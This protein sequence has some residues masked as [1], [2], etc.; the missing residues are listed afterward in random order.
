MVDTPYR[1][2]RGWA[3]RPR[4]AA[5]AIVA[6]AYVAAI[7]TAL[8]VVVLLKDSH[9][10][11][12]FFW[13]DIAATVVV[14]AASML[15]ANSSLYDPYWSVAPP[16]IIGGLL[17]WHLSEVDGSVT[18][19]HLAMLLL[20]LIWAMR[21]TGNWATGWTGLGH[22]DWRYIQMRNDTQGR[23]PWWVVSFVGIQLVPTL[24]V[25]AGLLPAWPAI[26][27]ERPFGVLDVLAILV[28]AGAIFLEATA[29][30]Q[31]RA[32]A[33]DP[34]NRGRTVN[35]GLWRHSRH[36]NYLGEISFWW[37]LWLFGLAAA[38]AWWWTVIGPL[39]MV[40]LFLG[41][42]IPLME[43]RSLA[44]RTDFAAYK[45]NVPVLLPWPR[46]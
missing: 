16:L 22:E 13:A 15:L 9:P 19:R 20:V 45:E 8:T 42:S 46:K 27:G 25:F 12:A 28:M 6:I 40:G 1:I 2:G 32:F 43:R 31:M 38:P 4:P 21:L 7:L 35:V 41:V 10:L 11:V 44:R 14:F 23:L 29:D 37:G 18:L 36:P 17:I 33:A 34:A 26:I 5:F 24:V 3:G 30:R 39:I